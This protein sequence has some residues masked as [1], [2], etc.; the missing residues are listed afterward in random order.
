MKKI[1]VVILMLLALMVTACGSKDGSKDGKVTLKFSGLTPEHG[2]LAAERFKEIAEAEDPSL[3]IVLYQKN[4][5]GDDRVVIESTRLGDIDI[6]ASS[7]SPLASSFPNFYLY[8]TPYLFLNEEQVD[9]VIDGPVTEKILDELESNNLKGLGMW[10]NGFRN[11]TG[12]A[13]AVRTPD[14]VRGM[15]LR[16]ME[17]E[18]HIAAWKAIGAN[19]TPMAFSEL[20]T[21]LQQGTIDGQ[22]NPFTG[23]ESAKLQEVQK[24]MTVTEHVWTPWILVMNLEK[25]NSLNESQQNAI[26]KA[27]RASVL[28]SR[29][30]SRK[31]D[32]EIRDRFAADGIV[33]TEL[34]SE[35]KQA[36]QEKVMGGNIFELV[37]DR[38]ANPEYLDEVANSL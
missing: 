1:S 20:F 16:T 26:L 30:K 8:D 23:I 9:A 12:S 3:E 25:F 21:A 22:E 27:A 38:M 28:E 10:E 32:R 13:K 6:A 31:L 11:L 29:E 24:Y 4:I 36:W 37:K 35:E 34:T 5:L 15:K 18:V 17:N 19:P 14:D 2:I 7:T 33:I